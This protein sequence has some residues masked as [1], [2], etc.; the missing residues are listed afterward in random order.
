MMP[1]RKNALKNYTIESI[2]LF[3]TYIQS[4]AS[5]RVSFLDYSHQ[6]GWKLKDYT[7][8]THLNEQA[9]DRFSNQLND[10]IVDI[11]NHRRIFY[12]SLK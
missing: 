10:T 7:D 12:D 1:T 3:T 6:K 4:F 2:K 9:A 8:V 11:L 5:E